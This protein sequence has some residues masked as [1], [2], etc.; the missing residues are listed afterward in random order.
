PN[1]PFTKILIKKG[2]SDWSVII[3][4]LCHPIELRLYEQLAIYLFKPSLNAIKN[5]SVLTQ[6]AS[7]DLS[8]AISLAHQLISLFPSDHPM[9]YR[10]TE[11][12]EDLKQTQSTFDLVRE[13]DFSKFSDNNQASGK[14][15]LVYDFNTGE[16]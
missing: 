5:I 10:F 16:L 9:H 3:L 4:Q 6:F 14:P 15:V 1:N 8:S 11:M 12:L 7:D 2:G 13:L